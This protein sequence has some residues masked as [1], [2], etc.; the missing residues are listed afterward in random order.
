MDG[1]ARDSGG[2]G[3][4]FD[5]F[6]PPTSSGFIAATADASQDII[7]DGKVDAEHK[8]KYD[9]NT[10]G[11]VSGE[12]AMVCARCNMPGSD[13]RFLPCNCTVH[14]V[15]RTCGNVGRVN[16]SRRSLAYHLRSYVV[17]PRRS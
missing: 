8:P 10:T 9:F 13:L 16:L 1:T 2:N 7:M 11:S 4:G 6:D 12:G 3:G 5:G 17:G 15:S 14:S